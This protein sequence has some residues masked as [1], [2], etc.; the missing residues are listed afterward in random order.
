LIAA[1][2]RADIAAIVHFERPYGRA[3][4]PEM[5]WVGGVRLQANAFCLQVQQR[6]S[7]G[8]GIGGGFSTVHEEQ[9]PAD[10][11]ATVNKNVAEADLIRLRK[12]GG[13]RYTIRFS[14]THFHHRYDMAIS[15][16]YLI[17][18]FMPGGD[19][20]VPII[21]ETDGAWPVKGKPLE[22]LRHGAVGY[23]PGP[24]VTNI[25]FRNGDEHDTGVR[26]SGSWS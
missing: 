12:Y 16:Q 22:H 2:I 4:E 17:Q 10:N 9:T 25:T 23:W 8:K 26:H 24:L 6:Q 7:Q 14:L 21:I 5:L 3:S 11:P 15:G 19:L 1:R 20:D 18:L 13:R